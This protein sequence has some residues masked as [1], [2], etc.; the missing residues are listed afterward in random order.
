MAQFE[1][2]IAGNAKFILSV[3]DPTQAAKKISELTGQFELLNKAQ[4]Q[5]GGTSQQFAAQQENINR[6][7]ERQHTLMGQTFQGIQSQKN[8][9]PDPSEVDNSTNAIKRANT[10]I[11]NFS[12]TLQDRFGISI[13]SVSVLLGAGLATGIVGI[14]RIAEQAAAAILKFAQELEELDRQTQLAF[15]GATDAVRRFA[16]EA[17]S[18]FGVTD[19]AILKLVNSFALLGR[20]LDIPSQDLAGFSETLSQLAIGLER[21]QPGFKDFEA[22]QKTIQAAIKGSDDAMRQLGITA[23]QEVAESIR[24]FGKLPGDLTDIERAQVLVN[25]K[26]GEAKKALSDYSA[27]TDAFTKINHLAVG[28]VH[29]LNNEL[30]AV[31]DSAQAWAHAIQSVWNA[32]PGG[33]ELEKIILGISGAHQKNTKST[34]EAAKSQKGFNDAVDAQHPLILQSQS[35][36]DNITQAVDAYV[37]AQTDGAKAVADAQERLNRAVVDSGRQFQ[38]VQQENTRALQD[39]DRTLTQAEEAFVAAEQDRVFRLQQADDQVSQARITAARSIRTANERL[40]DDERSHTQKIEDL[41]HRIAEA[42]RQTANA[43][44]DAQLA[45]EAALRKGNGEQFNAAAI[46]LSRAEQARGAAGTEATA[47]RELARENADFA[48]KKQRDIRAIQEAEQDAARNITRA[49]RERDHA[50]LESN[51]QVAQAQERIDQARIAR[52]R[53][54]TDNERR[55]TDFEIQ[56]SRQ[57]HD[58][59]EAL[60]QANLQMERSLESAGRALDRLASKLGTTIEELIVFGQELEA[61]G[62]DANAIAIL[63]ELGLTPQVPARHR[64]AGGPLFRGQASFVG[65]RGVELFVPNENGTVVSNEDLAKLFKQMGGA[66]PHIV[67][68][69]VASDPRATAWK[70]SQELARGVN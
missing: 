38:Q 3:D 34:D 20:E 59:A 37:K 67:I 55:L 62:G 40:Q 23:Q 17:V 47:Q 21:T 19:Q 9:L 45:L 10:A 65:E 36:I 39:A 66:S 16:D 14:I 51:R 57:L 49:V 43:I 41:Q 69:E 5:G 7:L 28:V 64:A 26:F 18:N 33:S 6:A 25:L 58:A 2:F 31:I 30:S 60:R 68:N 52:Q 50:I 56:S 54:I 11:D 70:V 1:E 44:L 15:G 4:A 24:A 22:V 35:D 53:V 42:H 8:I 61:F 63:N 46:A 27:E 12:H 29:E 13:R 48:I 32:I